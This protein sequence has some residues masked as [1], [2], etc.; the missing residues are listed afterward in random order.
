[1]HSKAVVV[2]DALAMLGSYNFNYRSIVWDTENAVI[3]TD[4]EAIDAVHQ[5]VL[6]DLAVEGVFEID[7]EW[8]DAVPPEERAAWQRLHNLGWLF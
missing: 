7:R 2:D 4:P 1:M 3:F 6:D 8:L 5:M